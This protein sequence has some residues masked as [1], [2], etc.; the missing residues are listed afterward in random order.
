MCGRVYRE[1][2]PSSTN[3]NGVRRFENCQRSRATK[4]KTP[5]GVHSHYVQERRNGDND[6]IA[7]SGLDSPNRGDDSQAPQA[8]H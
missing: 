3:V 5:L 7:V 6:G 4:K 1:T 8:T 2:I